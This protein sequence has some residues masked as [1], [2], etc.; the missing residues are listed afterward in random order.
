MRSTKESPVR[1]RAARMD[2]AERK[3]MIVQKAVDYFAEHGFGGS[4]REL[5]R[6]IGVTQS[7]LYRYFPTKQAL[8]DEVYNQ[9]Y[10]ARWNPQWEE[11]LRD[12]SKPFERRLK[13]Y[14]LEYAQNLIQNDWVRILILAGLHQKGINNKLFELLQKGIFKTV[15]LEARHEYGFVAKP[16]D[17]LA[18]EIEL[19]WAL[20]AS[21][22]Y[23]GMRRWVYHTAT[24]QNFNAVIEALVEGF[25]ESV[26]H[27]YQKRMRNRE[28]KAARG[29]TGTLS[30]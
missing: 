13:A 20:H 25:M 17:G 12:R 15:V 2:P 10:L 22:F 8:F 16:R 3:R 11:M 4:T 1:R 26:A 30:S 24:P 6:Q 23:I 29:S 14:Y 28:T 5:A 18:L 21:I 19:V 9:V 27:L 7:L